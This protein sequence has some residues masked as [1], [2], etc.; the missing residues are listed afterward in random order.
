ML[1]ILVFLPS[2]TASARERTDK[3]LILHVDGFFSADFF[4]ELEAGRLP[5]IAK[6]FHTGQKVKHG[7]TLYPGATEIIMPRLKEGLDSFEGKFVG[8]GHL[9]RES[10]A[11]V[12]N[13]PISLE[14]ILGFDRRNRHQFALGIP[15]LHHLAGLSLLNLERIWETQDVVEFYW[16]HSDVMG[17]LCGTEKHLDSLHTFDRYLGLAARGGK[18]EDVNLVLYADHGM[19]TKG[20]ETVRYDEVIE[21]AVSSELRYLAHPNIYLHDEGQKA[22]LAKKIAEETEVQIALIRLSDDIV[23]GYTATGY[24]DIT[25]REGQY[26]YEYVGEDYFG[27]A[28]LGLGDFMSRDEWFRRTKDH[29]YP[30]APPNLFNYLMHPLVGDIVGL[31]DSPKIPYGPGIQ[32]GNHSGLKNSDLVIPLLLA[33]PA[34]EDLEPIEEFWLHELFSVHLPMIDF[35]ARS[36]E[37]HMLSLGYPGHLELVLSPAYRWRTGL[38][39]SGQGLEPWLE[40]D[41][42][43]SFLTRVWVGARL[44]DSRLNWQLRVEGFLGDLGVSWLVHP[45]QENLL[46]LHWRVPDW[47]ELAVA[48]GMVGV[49]LVF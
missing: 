13:I 37:K 11:T 20:V 15:G 27:Y 41:L 49:S 32:K 12:G 18:L 3:F 29:I 44:C 14:L 31:L 21:A 46:R 10:G 40:Y 16:F 26:A 48:K 39:L 6:L 25:H 9:D 42:Y 22:R 28:E 34:F 17:H 2:F 23:R 1:V 8:W 47:A 33:G 38:S 5:N 19:T 45:K 36:R 4:R 30:A 43:S 35:D 24:F 7:I